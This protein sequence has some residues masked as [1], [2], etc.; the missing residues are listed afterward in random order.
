MV[1]TGGVVGKSKLAYLLRSH[2]SWCARLLTSHTL[3]SPSHVA[4][5]T[6]ASPVT[7]SSILALPLLQ[8]SLI[9]ILFYFVLA[10][11]LK[12]LPHPI[13]KLRIVWLCLSRGAAFFLYG[14]PCVKPRSTSKLDFSKLHQSLIKIYLLFCW[15]KGNGVLLMYVWYLILE[16][17][18]VSNLLLYHYITPMVVVDT[19]TVCHLTAP[20]MSFQLSTHKTGQYHILITSSP[21]H[22]L[23]YPIATYIS[24]VH[25]HQNELSNPG[26]CLSVDILFSIIMWLS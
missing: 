18:M 4:V 14:P 5:S 10:I 11:P 19:T 9:S 6:L 24:W 20:F 7:T 15:R 26:L 21:R 16:N 8:L 22:F 23:L 2:L 17:S 25:C 3:V 12:P 13:V 1:G